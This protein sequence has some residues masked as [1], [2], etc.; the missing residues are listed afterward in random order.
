MFMTNRGLFA[1]LAS[2]SIVIDAVSVS[3]Y[4]H[5][6]DVTI[7]VA[8]YAAIVA[9]VIYG[10][11]RGYKIAIALLA[12]F[13]AWSIVTSS[14]YFSLD[15]DTKVVNLTHVLSVWMM[16]AALVIYFKDGLTKIAK[17]RLS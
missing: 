14:R 13:C 6:R 11:F 7:F 8:I 10:A 4:L 3:I 1:I 5:S 9:F 15:G 2:A 17:A 16:V 12:V